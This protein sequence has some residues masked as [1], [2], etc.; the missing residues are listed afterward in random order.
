MTDYIHE[1]KETD[2][3]E[4]AVK[5]G[6]ACGAVRND[7]YLCQMGSGGTSDLPPITQAEI[8]AAIKRVSIDIEAMDNEPPVNS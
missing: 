4:D 7:M 2:R 6:A 8:D 1:D 5:H 3:L